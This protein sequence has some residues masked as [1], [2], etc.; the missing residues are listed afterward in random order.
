[1]EIFKAE[2][3]PIS[4]AYPT[5][6]ENQAT[7][8]LKQYLQFI[9]VSERLLVDNFNY[10]R[11]GKKCSIERSCWKHFKLLWEKVLSKF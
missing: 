7:E 5:F 2:V 11:Q 1:M 9:Y 4:T 10:M 3:E 6:E 8:S